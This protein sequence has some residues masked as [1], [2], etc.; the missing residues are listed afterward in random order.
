MTKDAKLVFVL[1]I[2]RSIRTCTDRFMVATVS[3]PC[4]ATGT[5]PQARSALRLTRLPLSPTT[6]R[7][8]HLRDGSVGALGLSTSLSRRR[9]RYGRRQWCC[10]TFALG[11]AVLRHE[12]IIAKNALITFTSRSPTSVIC[13]LAG[14]PLPSTRKF[15]VHA[16][17]G[18]LGS[19]SP[20]CARTTRSFARSAPTTTLPL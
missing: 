14:K 10:R 11:C 1:P 7:R 6:A 8:G 12:A 4:G 18:A 2:A 9:P 15:S 16:K 5:V 20:H 3:V 19:A 17:S 13:G